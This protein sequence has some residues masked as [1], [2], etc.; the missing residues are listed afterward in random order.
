[1]DEKINILVLNDISRSIL[2]FLAKNLSLAFGTDVGVSRHIIIPTTLFN[3]EKGQYDGKKLLKFLTENMTLKEVKGINLALFDRDLFIGS[4]DYAFGLASPFPKISVVSILRL[5]PHFQK[6]YFACGLKKRKAGRFPLF[7]RRLSG[8]EK[9][10][11]LNRIL[12]EAIHGM[13][14]SMGLTHCSREEC[15]MHSSDT[16]DD[17]DSK[18]TGFCKTCRDLL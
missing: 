17:I 12:K 9:A 3:E 16:I 14:H 15:I 4:L 2:R 1:M 8:Q 10:L 18:D 6:D 13:G 7:V 11:Y 5:H